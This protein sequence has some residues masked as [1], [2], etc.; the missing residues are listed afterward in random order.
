M[1]DIYFYEDKS[2]N[3]PAYD[4]ISALARKMIRIAVSNSIK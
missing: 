1:H 3:R 2:G 4:Y